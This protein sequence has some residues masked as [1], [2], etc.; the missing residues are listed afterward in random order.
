MRLNKE[1][2]EFIKSRILQYEQSAKIYLFGSRVYDFTKGG[3]VDFLVLSKKKI[4]RHYIRRVKIEFYRLF[5]WQRL[6]ILNFT[7]KES[8]SFKE[9]ILKNAIEI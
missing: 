4:D 2:A 5:G 7:F 3:D 9:L 8:N 6:D 1:I